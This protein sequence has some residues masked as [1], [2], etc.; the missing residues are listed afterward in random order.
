MK[1]VGELCDIL[2]LKTASSSARQDEK[3]ERSN[4]VN[5]DNIEELVLSEAVGETRN[6]DDLGVFVVMIP[7]FC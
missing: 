1:G 2:S 3:E 6:E 5:D 4:L 7:L